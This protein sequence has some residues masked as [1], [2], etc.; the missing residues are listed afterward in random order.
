MS[1]KGESSEVVEKYFL[2]PSEVQVGILI[3]ESRIGGSG[4]LNTR[5]IIWDT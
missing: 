5:H 3:L 1:G 4:G 2:A